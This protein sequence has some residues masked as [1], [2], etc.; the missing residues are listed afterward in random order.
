MSQKGIARET[1]GFNFR[2]G[3]RIRA[4]EVLQEAGLEQHVVPVELQ[5]APLP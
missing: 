4:L 1:D 2:S 5:E 3:Q